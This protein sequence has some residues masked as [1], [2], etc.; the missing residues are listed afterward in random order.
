MRA[1]WSKTYPDPLVKNYSRIRHLRPDRIRPDDKFNVSVEQ[2][3]KPEQIRRIQ[4]AAHYT[5][6]MMSKESDTN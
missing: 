1:T 4:A 2:K 5:R 3:Y 6:E